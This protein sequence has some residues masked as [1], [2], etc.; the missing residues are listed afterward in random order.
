MDVADTTDA[1]RAVACIRFVRRL[2]GASWSAGVRGVRRFVARLQD[3]KRKNQRLNECGN[4]HRRHGRRIT[5]YNADAR[6]QHIRWVIKH[7]GQQEEWTCVVDIPWIIIL[8]HHREWEKQAR[9]R[10]PDSNQPKPAMQ[11][12]AFHDLAKS[13]GNEL[14]ISRTPRIRRRR[15]ADVADTTDRLRAVACIN[16]VRPHLFLAWWSHSS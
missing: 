13:D 14:V 7:Y 3:K 2:V 9:E 6:C 12:D 4:V 16:F 15:G 8:L 11:W 5:E 1:I 10:D